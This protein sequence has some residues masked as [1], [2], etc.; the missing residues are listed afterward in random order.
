MSKQYL[1][2]AIIF[3][4]LIALLG[5]PAC[6]IFTSSPK[7]TLVSVSSDTPPPDKPEIPP[8]PSRD[9]SAITVPSQSIPS[10]TSSPQSRIE[11]AKILLYEDNGK[12]LPWVRETLDAMGL[13]YT[14]VTDGAIGDLTAQVKPGMEWDLIII[15]SEGKKAPIQGE[16]WEPIISQ[17]LDNQTALI[18]EIWNLDRIANGKISRLLDACG[19]EFQQDLA[20]V[21]PIYTLVPEHP[22]FNEPNSGISLINYIRYWPK[23]AGDLLR[24]APNSNATLLAGIK[25]GQ[26]KDYGVLASCLEGRV[27]IQTFS[28]HDFH[29]EIIKALWE[30]YIWYVLDNHAKATPLDE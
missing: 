2:T 1:R 22:V 12:L 16:V 17:V 15:D 26:K 19:I 9:G 25:D 13:Q 4:F 21:N 10:A 7:P 28:D 5:N 6:S 8:A 20:Q 29:E 3:W 23:K 14:E 27:L 24:L 30:N 11:N 18:A